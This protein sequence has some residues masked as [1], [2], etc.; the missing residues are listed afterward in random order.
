MEALWRTSWQAA[1]T[2]WVLKEI[3]RPSSLHGQPLHLAEEETEVPSW[4]HESQAEPSLIV[5]VPRAGCPH[6]PKEGS[7]REEVLGKG[8]L[9][10]ER[11]PALREG[12]QNPLGLSR[13]SQDCSKSP[14]PFRSVSSSMERASQ[15]QG[16]FPSTLGQHHLSHLA[17]E[18]MQTGTGELLMS[19]SG[20]LFL[21]LPP[22]SAISSQ[23]DALWGQP[24]APW[25]GEGQRAWGLPGLYYGPQEG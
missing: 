21:P 25:A 19:P 12:P 11:P 1:G 17:T 8:V 18:R 2:W 5:G 4:A 24:S 20:P 16:S 7:S 14:G 13:K 15:T 3:W 6:G 22:D 9:L 10:Q 23:L